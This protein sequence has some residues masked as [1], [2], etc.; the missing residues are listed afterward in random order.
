MKARE[1]EKP[2]KIKP[3]RM[4][5]IL[6]GKLDGES[7]MKLAIKLHTSVSRVSTELTTFRKDWKRLLKFVDDV[8]ATKYFDKQILPKRSEIM[9]QGQL[10]MLRKELWPFSNVPTCLKSVNNKLERTPEGDSLAIKIF[11]GRDQNKSL[12]ELHDETGIPVNT[13]NNMLKNPIYKGEYHYR[14][15]DFF[16][17]RLAIIDPKSWERVQPPKEHPK[18][19]GSP[20]FGWRW[21]WRGDI[22]VPENF[23]RVKRVFK[24]RLEGTSLCEI[25]KIVKLSRSTVWKII[26]NPVYKERGIV[27]PATWKKGQVA[28]R[29]AGDFLEKRA[30]DIGLRR[31][32][33]IMRVLTE[34]KR[35]TVKDVAEKL[36]LSWEQTDV[37]LKRMRKEGYLDVNRPDKPSR[38]KPSEWY[39]KSKLPEKA[40]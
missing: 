27:D 30:N 32:M 34:C 33:D 28:H 17:P 38:C 40:K 11:E 5:Q 14:G 13:L 35:A 20:P 22:E 2:I 31:R 8:R 4:L 9:F 18:R 15:H 7:Q 29:I 12:R 24:E 39:I 25:S 37:W 3:V 10:Q 26:R 19:H 21:T 36:G 23:E 1:D 16:W 6:K